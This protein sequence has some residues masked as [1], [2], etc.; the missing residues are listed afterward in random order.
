MPP[1]TDDAI[2]SGDNTL[3]DRINHANILEYVVIALGCLVGLVII[4]LIVCKIR[5]DRRKNAA[6]ERRRQIKAKQRQRKSLNGLKRP[7]PRQRSVHP[8]IEEIKKSELGLSRGDSG[9]KSDS[10]KGTSP[11]TPRDKRSQSQ[12]GS[13]GI[14]DTESETGEAIAMQTIKKPVR[15]LSLVDNLDF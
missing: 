1:T 10:K 14:E 8:R 5:S 9:Y 12:R 13:R 4:L 7:T 3:Q 2:I 15:Q 11:R 6:K